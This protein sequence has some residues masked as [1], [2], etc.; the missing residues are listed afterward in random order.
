M[1]YI[2]NAP[3]S[4]KAI[5]PY[6]QAVVAGGFVYTAG[7]LGMD[8]NGK[9]VN[10]SIEDET[11]QIMSN[12]QAVL[13]AANC[14]FADVVSATI[15]ITDASLFARINPIYAEY[16]EAGQAPAR[17]TVVAQPP[18]DGASIE[19]NMIALAPKGSSI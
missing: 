7:Q 8:N 1:Q 13:A 19:I 6:S 2:T 16:F 4:Y 15:Y 11:R 17:T 18:I 12:L 9:L 10:A 14:K 3:N 5:G